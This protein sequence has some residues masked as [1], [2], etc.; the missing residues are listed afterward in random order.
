MALAYLDLE[1]RIGILCWDNH[2]QALTGLTSLLNRNYTHKHEPRC[3]PI[4]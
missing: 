1:R 2:L 3:V 4:Q